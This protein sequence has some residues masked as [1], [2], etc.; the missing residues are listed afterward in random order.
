MNNEDEDRPV[1]ADV[2][3]VQWDHPRAEASYEAAMEAIS[4]VIGRLSALIFEE[5]HKDRP[6]QD[7]VG[8]L[9]GQQER[10]SRESA[11]LRLGDAAQ[12]AG[13]RRECARLL[14]GDT[15]RPG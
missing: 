13:I 3:P 7:R 5:E 8:S 2:T 12:I 4:Q 1:L 9:L 15:L 6:D 14:S 11:S 10:W